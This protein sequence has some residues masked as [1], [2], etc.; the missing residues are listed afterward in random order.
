MHVVRGSEKRKWINRDERGSG[1]RE[2]R[3]I[4]SSINSLRS[5]T[6]DGRVGRREAV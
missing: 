1:E 2:T 4:S 6:M 3:K 5:S